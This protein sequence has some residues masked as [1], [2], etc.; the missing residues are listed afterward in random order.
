M[1][2]NVLTETCHSIDKKILELWGC[3]SH[4]KICFCVRIIIQNV[5]SSL[6]LR[7]PSK[8][9]HQISSYSSFY[10][11]WLK[12]W[13]VKAVRHLSRIRNFVSKCFFSFWVGN[14]LYSPYEEWLNENRVRGIFTQ[15][16]TFGPHLKCFILWGGGD[17]RKA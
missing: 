14:S 8:F 5:V 13:D 16:P 3:L 2:F 4:L 7:Q 12:L 11:S 10:N 6:H 17:V 1:N 9:K 15:V